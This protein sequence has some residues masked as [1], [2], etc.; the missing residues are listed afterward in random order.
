[1]MGNS[2][3]I[4]FFTFTAYFHS[5]Q[6]KSVYFITV[7]LLYLFI[8]LSN[9]LLVVVIVLNR[10]LHEPMYMF[11]C[12]L[13]VNE[14][15]GSTGLF[16]LLMVQILSD[17]H[18]ISPSFCFLQIFCYYS[19]GGVEFWM[20]SIMSYDRYLSI[21]FP[22]QYNARMTT[23]KV[24]SLI[25]ASWLIPSLVVTVKTLLIIPLK[26]CRSDVDKVYCDFFSVV[27]LAC[28]D[29][30]VNNLYEL[31][32]ASALIS[33]NVA[34]ILYS[35]TRI[36]RVCFSGSKQTRQKA[37]STCAPHLACLFNFCFG[38][39]F[40]VVQ[41]RYD[42]SSVPNMLRIFLS[43][44]FITCQPLFNPLMYGLRLSK[45]RIKCRSLISA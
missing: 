20:L 1:M 34:V 21:C 2:T 36:L 37:V 4:S 35:Y 17:I 31:I 44:Y 15:Y 5:G 10:S 11:L 18:T 16:F 42:M 33:C 32:S 43:L 25:A 40:N 19:Y 12:S 28:D 14:L 45:I 23:N 39:F 6:L 41:S 29:T 13:F 30:T 9:V 27:K 7:L 22:L 3:Q 38:L 24:F 8:V 26:L